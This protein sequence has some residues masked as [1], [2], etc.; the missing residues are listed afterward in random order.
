[1]DDY[2]ETTLFS[3]K[4]AGSIKLNFVKRFIEK[5]K[6]LEKEIAEGDVRTKKRVDKRRDRVDVTEKIRQE[7]VDDRSKMAT[8]ERER[9]REKYKDYRPGYGFGYGNNMG[10]DMGT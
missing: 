3:E 7:Q 5:I 6:E 8:I 10:I 2:F 9:D 1:M 4:V